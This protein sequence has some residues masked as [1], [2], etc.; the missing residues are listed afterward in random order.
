MRTDSFSFT[1]PAQFSFKIV[2]YFL[3]IM[4]NVACSVI[5]YVKHSQTN[6]F[7]VNRLGSI[8]AKTFA[9]NIKAI[10]EE[11]VYSPFPGNK[12]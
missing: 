1:V 8:K 11:I 5:L 9:Y 3:R 6:A 12:I 4:I 2:D 10:D 7:M